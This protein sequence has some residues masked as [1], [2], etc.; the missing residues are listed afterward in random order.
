[1]KKLLIA[2]SMVG[3]VALIACATDNSVKPNYGS[4]DWFSASANVELD[5]IAA[6]GGEF[7]VKTGSA[8]TYKAN[9]GVIEIDG[10][11]VTDP[12]SFKVDDSYAKTTGLAKVTFELEASVVPTNALPEAKELTDVKTAFALVASADKATTNF[13]AWVKNG[14]SFGWQNLSFTNIPDVD[15]SYDLTMKF[16]DSAEEKKVQFSVK[17]E[18]AQAAEVSGWYTY[19]GLAEGSKPQIDFVGCGKLK[20]MNADQVWVVS[21]EVVIEGGGSVTID[22]KDMAAMNKLVTGDADADT[23]EKVLAKPVKDT[24]TG[25][26]ITIDGSCP[27]TTAEAYAIG[28]IAKDAGD[29]MVANADGTFKVKADAQANVSGGIPVGFVTP[30]TPNDTTATFSYQL[31]GSTD[32]KTAYVNVGDP[33]DIPTDIKIPTNKVGASTDKDGKPTGKYRYFKVVTTVTLAE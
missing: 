9:G 20:R 31:Q 13:Y 2:F 3:A 21:S 5:S 8:S 18:A 12:V 26:K 33:V 11:D 10:D 17:L 25:G 1:M 19:G 24:V 29:T 4:A 6:V 23:I 14:T 30:L 32:G 7:S 27:L 16:D 15:G 28:L 22:E